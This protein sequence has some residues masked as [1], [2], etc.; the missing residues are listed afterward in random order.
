MKKKKALITGITGQDG[1]YLS[2]LLLGMDYEVHGLA[3]RNALNTIGHLTDDRIIIHR[4]DLTDTHCVTK[5]LRSHKFD[6]IYHLGAQTFVK[7]SFDW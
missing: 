1:Y 5:I 4:G 3:R 6:E 7:Q 2:T